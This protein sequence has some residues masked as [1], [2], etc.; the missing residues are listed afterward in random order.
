MLTKQEG[1]PGPVVAGLLVLAVA[2]PSGHAL[3]PMIA[4]A[5]SR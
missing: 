4:T 3:E 1:I 5:A 2:I